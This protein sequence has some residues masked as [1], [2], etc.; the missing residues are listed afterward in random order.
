MIEGVIRT[1]VGY[2]GG[3]QANPTYHH[4]GDHT[5]TV[6]VDYDPQRISYSQLLTVF[7]Q[8]H[9]PTGRSRSRQYMRAIFYSDDNQRRLALESKA[10]LAQQIGQAVQTD[11]LPL[12]S[13]TMA[14]NYHQKYLLKQHYRLNA[15]MT[16]I[17]PQHHDFVDSTAVARLNGYVGGY[18]NKGQFPKD[19]DR[20]GLSD[21][22]KTALREVV[23]RQWRYDRQ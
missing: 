12:R 10:A 4:I 11:V 23:K 20:L 16:R 18:G 21:A 19:I 7:W 15:E 8:S 9:K 5:E 3:R 14:E 13:F 2:A 6:Q 22:G 17:Y 1:R